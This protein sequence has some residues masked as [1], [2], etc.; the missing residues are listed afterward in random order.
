MAMPE[1]SMNKDRFPAAKVSDVW[2]ARQIS[3]MKTIAW[4]KFA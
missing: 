4:G 3:T 1:T 2:N